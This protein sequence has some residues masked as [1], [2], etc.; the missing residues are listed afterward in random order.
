MAQTFL[1]YE[2]IYCLK[3]KG[4]NFD[5]FQEPASLQA[6][7]LVQDWQKQPWIWRQGWLHLH[8]LI[9]SVTI[10]PFD[11]PRQEKRFMSVNVSFD[12]VSFLPTSISKFSICASCSSST[13]KS[14]RC[15]QQKN[16]SIFTRTTPFD[17]K[18]FHGIMHRLMPNL[19]TK[20]DRCLKNTAIF[21]H[22]KLKHIFI[23][24]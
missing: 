5:E 18:I 23:K 2:F 4:F 21:Q 15:L 10:I 24:S 3:R 6:R 8:A 22:L 7:R 1:C 20:A 11:K 13:L 9:R 17:P 12:S 16:Y 19:M 14:Q